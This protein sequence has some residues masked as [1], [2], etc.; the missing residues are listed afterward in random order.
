MGVKDL[1]KLSV[2]YVVGLIFILVCMAAI[3]MASTAMN[4]ITRPQVHEVT[5]PLEAAVVQDLCQK[6]AL[7]EDD[8]L[9]LPGAVVYAPDF[10]PAVKAAFE[11]GITTYDDVQEKL[12]VYKYRQ[13]PLVIQADG[14]K[15]FRC[16]YD[17]NGDHVF[18][19]VFSFTDENVLRQ[20]FASAGDTWP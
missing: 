16:W 3:I 17:F 9:C 1:L 15:Y 10:F 2:T 12:G 6:L 18:P 11:P 14:V 5:S 13:D 8:P 7:P 20:I 19:I 4:I